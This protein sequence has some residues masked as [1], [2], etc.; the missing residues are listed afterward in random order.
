MLTAVVNA[1]T[2]GDNTIVAA[3]PSWA[4]RVIG[5]VLVPDTAVTAT[6]KS[7]GGTAL[8]GPMKLAPPGLAM[9]LGPHAPGGWQGQFESLTGEALVL[10][11]GAATQVSG[12]VVYDWVR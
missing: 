3:R 11:L 7:S 10:N 4:I 8:T 9:P 5:Y 6:F 1:A 2:L 12:Y